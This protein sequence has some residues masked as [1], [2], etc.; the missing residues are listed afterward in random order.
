[1]IRVALYSARDQHEP[2]CGRDV[3][4]EIREQW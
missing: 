2:A 4:V 3:S 1:M